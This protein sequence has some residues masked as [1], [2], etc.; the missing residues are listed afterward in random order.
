M[1]RDPRTPA[2]WREAAVLASACL[3]IDDAR[4]Y[5]FTEGGPS[6]DRERCGEVLADA[7]KRGIAPTA[8]ETDTAALAIVAQLAGA[9]A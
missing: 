8:E 2:E 7:A 1:S 9:G 4:L 6:I 3:L 5:G